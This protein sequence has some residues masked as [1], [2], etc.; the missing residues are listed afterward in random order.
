MRRR[1][2]PTMVAINT[3]IPAKARVI[4]TLPL[5]FN[6]EWYGSRRTE[7]VCEM[8]T[9]KEKK[10]ERERE[11]EERERRRRKRK[12]EEKKG[13]RK[14]KGRREKSITNFVTLLI[15]VSRTFDTRTKNF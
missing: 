1:T 10:E 9:E 7:Y 8:M 6:F 3:A 5:H 14:K 2:T 15:Q 13:R 11:E 4:N 12:K